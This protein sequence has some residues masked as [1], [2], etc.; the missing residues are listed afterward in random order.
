MD[1]YIPN[2]TQIKLE[3]AVKKVT[4]EGKA[5][6][7]FSENH[8]QV[9]AECQFTMKSLVIEAGDLDIIEKNKLDFIPFVESAHDIS[10]GF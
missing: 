7:G 5:F 2:S 9:I 8:S 10:E 3:L 6:Q 1:E 4:K